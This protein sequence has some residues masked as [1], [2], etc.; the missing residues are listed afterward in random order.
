MYALA[1]SAALSACDMLHLDDS[2]VRWH[3]WQQWRCVSGDSSTSS[4]SVVPLLHPCMHYLHTA[5]KS[6]SASSDNDRSTSCHSN[7]STQSTIVTYVYTSAAAALTRMSLSS[8]ADI[9]CSPASVRA[10][11]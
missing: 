2:Y 9:T 11:V 3:W 1:H 7:S 10:T 8:N 5:Y 6:T 4:D